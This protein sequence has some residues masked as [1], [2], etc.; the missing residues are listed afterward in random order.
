M[1]SDNAYLFS[2]VILFSRV[3]ACEEKKRRQKSVMKDPCCCARQNI[4]MFEA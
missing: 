4:K 3:T 2:N 1:M